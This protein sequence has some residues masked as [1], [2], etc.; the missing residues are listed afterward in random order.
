MRFSIR[1]ILLLTVIAAVATAWGLDR[2]RLARR[3][4]D[5][6]QKTQLLKYEAEIARLQAVMQQQSAQLSAQAALQRAETLLDAQKTFA[7]LGA[8]EPAA[9]GAAK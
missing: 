4:A 5:I 9:A 7:E 3:L 8:A 2:W 6:E 1:D